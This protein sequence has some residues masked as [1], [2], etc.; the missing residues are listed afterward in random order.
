MVRLFAAYIREVLIKETAPGT[1]VI[2]DN[3]A[4]RR[5]KE[6]VQ[7]LRDHGCWFLYP[8]PYYPDLN[9]IEQAYS[10]LKAHLRRIRARTF[11]NVFQAIGSICDLHD[12]TECW[13]Y[14]KSA[15]YTS[16]QKQN[17][18]VVAE[19]VFEVAPGQNC[20]EDSF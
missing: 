11:T 18:L 19:F 14:F 10:K 17:A 2:L 12:P 7:A 4:T 16:G 8:P 1:V 5:T 15:G 13:N 6:A 3:L 20:S 9:P